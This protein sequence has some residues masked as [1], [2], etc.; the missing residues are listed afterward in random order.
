MSFMVFT[1]FSELICAKYTP[2]LKKVPSIM[3]SFELGINVITFLPKILKITTDIIGALGVF[4]VQLFT[5]G[6]G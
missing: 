3:T 2:E 5:V 1:L 4:K 6:F